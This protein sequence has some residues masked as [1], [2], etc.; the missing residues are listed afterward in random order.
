MKKLKL[1][2]DSLRVDGFVLGAAE[3]EKGTVFGEQSTGHLQCSGPTEY[4]TC[5]LSC[6]PSCLGT[7]L[8]HSTCL[9]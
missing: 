2:M 4:M 1:E 8:N 6:S 9:C 7:C 5:Q 3:R